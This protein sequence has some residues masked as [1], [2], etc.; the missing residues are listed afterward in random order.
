MLLKKSI[1]Y[2]NLFYHGVFHEANF[3]NFINLLTLKKRYIS[4]FKLSIRKSCLAC[5]VCFFTYLT[6]AIRSVINICILKISVF[7]LYWYLNLVLV[8]MRNIGIDGLCVSYYLYYWYRQN[9]NYWY[10]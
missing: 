8:Q 6:H 10:R 3:I 4:S 2:F 9:Q 1:P 7:F 5:I